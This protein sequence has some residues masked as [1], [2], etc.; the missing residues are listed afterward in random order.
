VKILA[1][2]KKYANGTPR[3]LKK[4]SKSHQF[5]LKHQRKND[6]VESL[7]WMEQ[8]GYT[9]LQIEIKNNR[10]GK[11]ETF[12]LQEDLEVMFGPDAGSATDSDLDLI[13]MMYV[14]DKYDVSGNAYHEMSRLCKGLPRSYKIKQRISELNKLWNIFPTPNGIC[15]V[16]QSL[17]E[18]LRV[19]ISELHKTAPSDAAFR[20]N[21]TV[22]VKLS[23]D[24]TNIGKGLHG[25]NFT[26]TLLEGHLHTVVRG[27]TP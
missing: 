21:K 2:Q 6:C 16:Q 22:N 25:V 11:L 7:K 9:S 24:G 15:G 18:W 13:S 26:F 17:E 8:E 1:V 4:Y 20:K 27:T 10:T 12:V 23:G 5:Q 14:K 19:R 3:S